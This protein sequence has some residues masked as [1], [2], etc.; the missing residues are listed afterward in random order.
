MAK[1]KKITKKF[2]IILN[3]IINTSI[4]PPSKGS[5]LLLFHGKIKMNHNIINNIPLLSKFPIF[6]KELIQPSKAKITEVLPYCVK[7]FI[8]IVRTIFI[9]FE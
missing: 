3:N 4:S 2:P 6:I 5:T 8:W 7:L 9:K 1:A